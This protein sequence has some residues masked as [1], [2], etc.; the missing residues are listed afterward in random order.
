[1]D[2][3]KEAKRL[4]TAIVIVVALPILYLLSSGPVIGLAFWLRNATGWDGF[5]YIVL[6][7]Y[8]LIRLDH[9]NVISQYI[10]WWIEDVFHTVGPG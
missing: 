5:Y 10:Q 2:E 1:M 3:S 6:L 9:L 8:P 7:Y 4:P